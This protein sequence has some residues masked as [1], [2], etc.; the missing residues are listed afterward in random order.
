MV[1]GTVRLDLAPVR[2][3]ADAVQYPPLELI[4]GRGRLRGHMPDPVRPG[5]TAVV[6]DRAA[7]ALV[8]T[9]T[10]PTFLKESQPA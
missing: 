5:P 7:R 9:D 1:A 10:L 4:L 6:P 8:H 3:I 2:G